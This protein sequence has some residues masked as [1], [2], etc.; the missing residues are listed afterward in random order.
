MWYFSWLLGIG[1]ALAFGVIN[2]MWLESR[3]PLEVGKQTT[4]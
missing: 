4:R 3:R 2:V 1:V